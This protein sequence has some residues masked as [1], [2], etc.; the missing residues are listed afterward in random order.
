[1]HI[2]DAVNCTQ[3]VVVVEV[4]V[5]DK[6]RVSPAWL[7]QCALS[8]VSENVLRCKI[9]C[10]KIEQKS[11]LATLLQ[12]INHLFTVS[13]AVVLYDVTEYWLALRQNLRGL[14]SKKEK[15]RNLAWPD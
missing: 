11:Q 9:S 8:H 7:V 6:F 10:V 14:M 13:A 15:G 12:T 5:C 1:V 3:S 4:I 2:C